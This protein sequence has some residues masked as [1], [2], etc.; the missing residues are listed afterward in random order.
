MVLIKIVFGRLFKE[1]LL[2]FIIIFVGYQINFLLQIQFIVFNFP[3]S[4]FPC[5]STDIRD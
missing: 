1:K 3:L 2:Y 4:E 5:S